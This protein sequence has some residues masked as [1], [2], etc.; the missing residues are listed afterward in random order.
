MPKARIIADR[1]A[2][3]RS[4]TGAELGIVSPSFQT[5]QPIEVL[6]F[7]RTYAEQAGAQLETAGALHGGKLYFALARIGEAVQ[8][9]FGDRVIPYIYLST[10][11]DGTRATEARFC[12]TRVVCANTD[13]MAR[14]EGKATHKTTHRTVWVAQNARDALETANREFGAY[15]EMARQLAEV[16]VSSMRAAELTEALVGAAKTE[17]G[18]TS[19]GFASIMS[20]FQGSGRG[21]DLPGSRG[22]AWGY[23]NA[24]TQFADFEVRATSVDNRLVSSMFG[25]GDKLKAAARDA[26]LQLAA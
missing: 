17:S 3:V 1:V 8:V 16:R 20:L 4:D 12:A 7:F 23:L 22:T 15:C 13:A 2:Q 9:A 10:A 11:C 26:V 14:G 21:A 6:E 19:Q 5:V 25:N 18:R 24:V